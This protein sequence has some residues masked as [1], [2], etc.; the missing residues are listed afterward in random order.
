MFCPEMPPI[1]HSSSVLFIRN[2][3]I[4]VICTPPLLLESI[5]TLTRAVG[6]PSDLN[7]VIGASRIF[8]DRTA[9]NVARVAPFSQYL[10]PEYVS[11]RSWSSRYLLIHS[12]ILA[13]LILS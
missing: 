2:V 9:Y 8:Q 10:K 1:R 13:P 6:L 5:I 4:F 11:P 12:L 3:Q 7:T